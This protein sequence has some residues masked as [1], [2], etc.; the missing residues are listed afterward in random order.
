[1]EVGHHFGRGPVLG[2]DDF[3]VEF[4]VA[5]NDVG[6][7]DHYGAVFDGGFLGRLAGVGIVDVVGEEELVVG[8]SVF[9]LGDAEDGAAERGDF[10]LEGDEGVGFVHA[11]RA[12]GGPEIEED[13]LAAEVG[14]A[15]GLAVES[16]GE[17][18]SGS[19]AKT[20]GA[21]AIVGADEKDYESENESENEDRFQV[22]DQSTLRESIIRAK[23]KE[24]KGVPRGGGVESE[25][26]EG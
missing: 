21:L 24:R 15:S 20:G 13:N 8:G 2:A 10:I 5:G 9:V 18:G 6:F 3:A 22:A 4:A 11:G 17:I 14:E 23:A 26:G 16:E 7:G 1:L 25:H 12:P 19:A